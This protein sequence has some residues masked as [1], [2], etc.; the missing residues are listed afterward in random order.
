MLP[1]HDLPEY[2]IHN[3]GEI[4]GPIMRLFEIDY[5]CGYCGRKHTAEAYFTGAGHEPADNVHDL[6]VHT[7][8]VLR[9]EQTLLDILHGNAA[10][11]H[12]DNGDFSQVMV[13][14]DARL[15][16]GKPPLFRAGTITMTKE[17]RFICDE[18]GQNF[19]TLAD[20]WTHMGRDTLNGHRVG[21]YACQP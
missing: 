10:V 14:A 1:E 19:P 4:P 5:L 9:N 20:R 3:P 21:P 8:A 12:Q 17:D 7:M 11:F 18:C 6:Y 16:Q 15:K 2:R 13:Q